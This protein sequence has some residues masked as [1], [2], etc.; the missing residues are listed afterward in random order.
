MCLPISN[1]SPSLSFCFFISLSHSLQNEALSTIAKAISLF[2]VITKGPQFEASLD[3]SSFSFSNLGKRRRVIVN[4]SERFDLYRRNWSE[5]GKRGLNCGGGLSWMERF[6][7]W[8]ELFSFS[9]FSLLIFCCHLKWFF[10]LT[11]W[12]SHE[13][14]YITSWGKTVK[15]FDP[16]RWMKQKFMVNL[17]YNKTLW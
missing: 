16:S 2:S 17:I 1:P 13:V 4:K 5:K 12:R 11:Q 8:P 7:A 14:G 6:K 9:F 3:R 10:F 15:L